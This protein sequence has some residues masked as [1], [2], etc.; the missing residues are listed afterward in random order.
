MLTK[1]ILGFLADEQGA[2]A[3]EYGLLAGLIGAS[4]IATFAVF[5][6]ELQNLFGGV[7]AGP[8]NRIAAAANIP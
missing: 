5:G 3:I 2:T 4:L 8:G 1:T 6:N 7:A